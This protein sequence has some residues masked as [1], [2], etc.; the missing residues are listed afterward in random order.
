MKILCLGGH[1]FSLGS[2]SKKL[3]GRSKKLGGN[4]KAPRLEEHL[5]S[6]LLLSS[7]SSSS[8]S[9]ANASSSR[10]AWVLVPNRTNAEQNFRY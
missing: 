5:E 1:N 9:P 10:H 2:P 8:S 6:W 4:S 3:G 7:S